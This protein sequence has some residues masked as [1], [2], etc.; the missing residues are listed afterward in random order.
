MIKIVCAILCYNNSKIIQKLINDIKSFNKI[1]KIDLIFIDDFS[2]DNTK[3]I[4]LSNNLKIIKHNT[5]LGY[6]AAVKSAFGYGIKNKKDFLLIFPGDYQRS[7]KDLELMIKLSNQNKFDLISGSK[8]KKI[9]LLPKHRKFGNLIYSKLAKYLWKSELEDVLS[10]FKS[11][12][13]K[14]FK[15]IIKELPD[16]YS[17]DIVL[18]Q[19]ISRKKILCKE[20]DA[21]VKYN[22]ETTQ[23][24]SFFHLGKKNILYIGINMFI[25][26]IYKFIELNLFKN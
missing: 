25:I 14:K 18:S 21:E 8:F 3:D 1:N 11:Y 24:K 26:T 7:L 4:I 12:K 23:M 13:I 16:N 5:N 20:F 22:K 15:N 6:G 19:I 10:G 9:K 17:F 2:K